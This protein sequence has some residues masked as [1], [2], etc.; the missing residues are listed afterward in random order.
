MSRWRV[1]WGTAS[2]GGRR[3]GWRHGLS[4]GERCLQ[5]RRDSQVR[6][7]LGR[8]PSWWG[9]EAGGHQIEMSPLACTAKIAGQ[10][11]SAADRAVTDIRPTWRPSRSRYTAPLSWPFKS[12]TAALSAYSVCKFWVHTRSTD[13]VP[14]GMYLH[15]HA[16]SWMNYFLI[17][18]RSKFHLG[19]LCN[20][21]CG[22]AA[23]YCLLVCFD[24]KHYGCLRL[25]TCGPG[26]NSRHYTTNVQRVQLLCECP[27]P[28]F[29][30]LSGWKCGLNSTFLPMTFHSSC[31]S[32]DRS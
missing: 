31:Y 6:A 20:T 30:V 19:G 13:H 12:T 21:R 27:F 10:V 2:D 7:T 3:P 15:C 29:P 24:S 9:R 5:G 28:M 4:Y 26:P 18:L 14:S 22:L 16:R 23:S 17:S 25:F 8:L 32:N 11:L 1:R